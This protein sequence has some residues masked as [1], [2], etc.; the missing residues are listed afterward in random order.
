MTGTKPNILFV[1]DEEQNLLAFRAAFRRLYQILVAHSAQVG[2]ELL[3]QE[4]IQVIIT[5]QRMPEM[6]ETEFIA[7]ILPEFP[8]PM[9]IILTG[10]GFLTSRSSTFGMLGQRGH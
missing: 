10:F 5:D 8:E 2:R 3:A 1:D 9:R 7:S 4:S 6:T